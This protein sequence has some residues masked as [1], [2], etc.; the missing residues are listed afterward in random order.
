MYRI[1]NEA[2]VFDP[3]AR[4]NKWNTGWQKVQQKE[5][6]MH[7]CEWL[8]LGMR[9]IASLALDLMGCAGVSSGGSTCD[10]GKDVSGRK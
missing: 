9:P 6:S 10:A 7:G 5:D 3:N 8:G 4:C 2:H 1:G